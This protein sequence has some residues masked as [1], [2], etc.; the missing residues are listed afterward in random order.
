MVK[1]L[2]EL[3][4]NKQ[5]KVSKTIKRVRLWDLE[6]QQKGDFMS[7]EQDFPAFSVIP[8]CILLN[9]EIEQGA[10][11]LFACLSV[12]ANKY[13]YAFPQ[14]EYL[15]GLLHVDERTITRW[16]KSLKDLGAITIKLETFHDQNGHIKT[17]RKVWISLDFQKMF[18]KGQKCLD[19][20]SID[21]VDKNVG[22]NN[23]TDNNK[24]NNPIV[25]LVSFGKYVQLSQE[26]MD[27]LSKEF[28]TEKIKAIIEEMNDYLEAHGKKPYKDYSAAIRIWIRKDSKEQKGGGGLVPSKKKVNRDLNVKILKSLASKLSDLYC[29]DPYKANGLKLLDNALYDKCRGIT[30]A[31]NLDTTDLLKQ[32]KELYGYDIKVDENLGF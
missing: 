3:L 23:N 10:K 22:H 13:G 29:R 25:P 19:G 15:S 4:I 6:A 17:N 30:L 27:K 24:T 9:E 8:T 26:N 28:G 11:L 31:Y 18:T 21:R 1:I 14:N 5:Q 12:M 7:T 20:E 16:F 2:Q 32:I